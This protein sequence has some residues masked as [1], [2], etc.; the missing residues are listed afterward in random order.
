MHTHLAVPARRAGIS[1]AALA[2]AIF[3]SV[4]PVQANRFGPPFMASVTVDQTTV[5]SQPDRSAQPVGG[6]PKGAIV[7]VTGQQGDWTRSPQGWLPSSD[8]A[9]RIEP[10]I[11]DVT[12]RSVSVYAKPNTTQGIRR[13]AEQGDLLMVTGVSPGVDGDQHLWWATTEGYVGL[14]TIAPTTNPWASHWFLATPEEAAQG[15][16]GVALGGNVR[17]APTMDAPIIGRFAGGERVK[18]LY[19]QPGDAV[20]G[21]IVWYRIDGGRFPGGHIHSS[22]IRRIDEPQP[23]IIPPNRDI[24]DQP[25]IVVDRSTATLTLLREGRPQFTTYVS[26]GKAGVD[27]PDGHYN[28]FG[29]YRAERMTSITNPQAEHSYD[30]PNVPY[31]QYFRGDGSAIHGTYWHDAFGTRQSQGCINVTWGDSAYLFTQ[32]LPELPATLLGFQVSGDQAT[33][34]VVVG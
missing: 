6:L 5:Y 31:V 9:E 10:W 34:V 11:G 21:S 18:V 2:L 15:W 25:W 19:S 23:S 3:T 14:D 16:W 1:L 29:K 30:L 13:T 7:V 17:A 27:T 12:E 4:V 26:L 33:P 8:L 28:T 20:D 22:L 32:T 24:G